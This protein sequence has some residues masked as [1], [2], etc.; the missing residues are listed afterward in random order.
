MT[1]EVMFG[2]DTSSIESSEVY[3]LHLPKMIS[4]G[5]MY[6]MSYVDYHLKFRSCLSKSV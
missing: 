2:G 4:Y 3:V 6:N 1:G 5:L